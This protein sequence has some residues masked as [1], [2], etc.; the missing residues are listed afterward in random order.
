MNRF[1]NK[2]QKLADKIT[3]IT[4]ITGGI[5][6]I[7]SIILSNYEWTPE[8]IVMKIIK[9]LGNNWKEIWALTATSLL[10][11]VWLQYIRIRRHLTLV[12]TDDFKKPIEHNWDHLGPWRITTENELYVTG[13]DEGGLT[14]KGA[15]WENYNFKFEA[16]ILNC[17]IGVIIRA[18]D[19]QNYYM[20]QITTEK[21]RPHRR[22][23]V[24]VIRGKTSEHKDFIVDEIRTGWVV[25]DNISVTHRKNLDSWFRVKLIVKG[26]SISIFINDEKVFSHNQLIEN[27]SGKVGFRNDT[28]EE[29]LIRNVKVEI[30]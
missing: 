8:S 16:K 22:V 11:Y 6:S 20:F 10:L 17:C 30:I 28:T 23:S 2:L 24:P 9:F 7:I 19:L 14:K 1:F 5:F 13:S 26:Q 27:S 4:A 15:Y 3:A 29:A 21:V 25:M 12:F 18:K